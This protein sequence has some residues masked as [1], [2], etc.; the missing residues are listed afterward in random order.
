[1]AIIGTQAIKIE[2]SLLGG[3]PC[4]Y[5]PTIV[6]GEM[7]WPGCIEKPV[8]APVFTE[9]KYQHR[10]IGGN[11]NTW[12]PT[13][14]IVGDNPCT[15]APTI[16]DGKM[17]W[18]GCDEKNG[19]AQVFAE[20][21]YCGN[22]W[23]DSDDENGL[24]QVFA[25]AKYCGNGWCDSDDENGL[26]QVDAEAEASAES[27]GD[28]YNAGAFGG[29]A[30]IQS[31]SDSGAKQS[32][33]GETDHDTGFFGRM[34]G[35]L[36]DLFAQIDDGFSLADFEDT[37]GNAGFAQTDAQMNVTPGEE[38]LGVKVGDDA[39]QIAAASGKISPGDAKLGEAG[40]GLGVDMLGSLLS[41]GFAQTDA[42]FGFGDIEKDF[43]G[44]FA[45]TDAGFGFGDIEK[46]FAGMFA[47]TDAQMNVTPG[48][49]KLANAVAADGL[50][51]A[52]KNGKM[53]P[54][55]AKLTEDGIG[56][57][58]D[59]LGSLLSNFHF[60]QTDAQ[61]NVTPGEE[62]LATAV[63]ADALNVAAKNGKI[64]PSEAQLGDIGVE[65]GVEGISDLLSN[66]HFSQTDA[67][68]N[69]TP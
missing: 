3:D 66:F 68:M 15:Y 67:Q 64:T 9:A 33:S 41:S 32:D 48:E 38:T 21:K 16:V 53:T 60:A 24:A 45:Q 11:P 37:L 47:Q 69:V 35:D 28:G 40:I 42:D 56:L 18:P 17:T 30:Q 36:E 2:R 6:D 39:L 65:V 5:A 63:G 19:L 25:E 46:A 26:A 51:I 62:K 12:T 29:F 58:V 52:V 23:C 13:H 44:M 4:T 1:M 59:L 22:G 54:G 20:A 27:Y 49:K 8:L 61:M 34:E 31:Q 50:N 43:A 57:G 7:T 55:E 10:P 14:E